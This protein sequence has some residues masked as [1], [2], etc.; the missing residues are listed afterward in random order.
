MREEAL[1]FSNLLNGVSPEQVAKDFRKKSVD[2]VLH[3]FNFVLRKVKSYCFLRARGYI[4]PNDPNKICKSYPIIPATCIKDAQKFRL[5]CLTV[6]PLLNLDKA[7]MYKDIQT[8]TVN[9]DNAAQ[10]QRNLQK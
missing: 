3:I 5:T 8:E 10:V 4:D 6:L 2:E 7:P 9:P 1:I